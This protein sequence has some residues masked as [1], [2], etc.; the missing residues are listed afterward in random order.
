MKS[1]DDARRELAE[2]LMLLAEALLEDED[3][4]EWKS[5][6][7]TGELKIT[8]VLGNSTSIVAV[9]NYSYEEMEEWAD[10]IE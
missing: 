3:A 1:R 10:V 4:G 8:S 9:Q 5:D 7:K 6:E 2:R